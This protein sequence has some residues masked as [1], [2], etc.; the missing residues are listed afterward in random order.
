MP[1]GTGLMGNSSSTQSAIIV[2]NPGNSNQFYIFTVPSVGGQANGL[3]FSIVDMS[4]N[5]GLGD[6]I[7]ASKN[8]LVVTNVSER[9]TAVKQANGNSYWIVTKLFNSLNFN[10]F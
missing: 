4:L 9:V 8:T 10:A 5:G 6:V 2:P 7:A 1:N 3:R